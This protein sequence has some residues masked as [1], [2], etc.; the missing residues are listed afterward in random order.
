MLTYILYKAVRDYS[1]K[2]GGYAKPLIGIGSPI[3]I[4]LITVVLRDRAALGAARARARV[5]EAQAGGRR[6]GRARGGGALM[7]GALVVGYDGT[8]GARAAFE[9]AIRLAKDLGSPVVAVF[10]FLPPRWGGETK[11]LDEAVEERARAVLAEAS[12]RGS[13]AGVEVLTELRPVDPV[14]ALMDAV[15]EHDGRYIVVGSYG[16][17][18]LKSAVVGSTPMKLVRL[19]RR[20]SWWCARGNRLARDARR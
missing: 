4:A 15:A 16:E 3:A 13:A 8:E 10:G 18:P 14:Q 2:D 6:P 1:A 7:P 11:D 9:E 5:L 20:P 17:G 12:E 19:S